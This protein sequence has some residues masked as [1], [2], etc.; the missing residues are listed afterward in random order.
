MRL[1]KLYSKRKYKS[2]LL[3]LGSIIVLLTLTKTHILALAVESGKIDTS[4]YPQESDAHK[5]ARITAKTI[6]S[7]A[8]I[9]PIVG[10]FAKVPAGIIKVTDRVTLKNMMHNFVDSFKGS[11]NHMEKILEVLSIKLSLAQYYALVNMSDDALVISNNI[12]DKAKSLANAAVGIREINKVQ[13]FAQ[14]SLIKMLEKMF[15]GSSN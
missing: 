1:A 7:F 15:K 9:I 2:L 5:G 8:A 13:L 12:I 3:I 10:Q 11:V 14:E 4:G 6:E